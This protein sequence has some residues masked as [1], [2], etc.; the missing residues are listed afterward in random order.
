V[1]DRRVPLVENDRGP[2]WRA[3]LHAS[4][5]AL[6]NAIRNL[7]LRAS[8]RPAM[9]KLATPAGYAGGTP[10]RQMSRPIAMSFRVIGRVARSARPHDMPGERLCARAAYELARPGRRR[11]FAWSTAHLDEIASFADPVSQPAAA[12]VFAVRCPGNAFTEFGGIDRWPARAGR[13]IARGD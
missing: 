1:V 4:A 9:R 13:Q 12:C 3:A 5:H 8:R 2:G 10:I 7:R 6:M 11:R